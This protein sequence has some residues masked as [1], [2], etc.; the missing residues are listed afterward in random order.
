LFRLPGDFFETVHWTLQAY[1]AVKIKKKEAWRP[2]VGTPA[3][4]NKRTAREK[5]S[6]QR[7]CKALA[8]GPLKNV[9]VV[10]R[11]C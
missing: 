5:K 11:L 4:G 7:Q 6:T 1:A 3:G 2:A 10:N 9:V 8:N